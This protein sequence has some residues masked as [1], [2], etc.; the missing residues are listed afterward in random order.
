MTLSISRI[1]VEQ[2]V[3]AVL[4]GSAVGSFALSHGAT[5]AWLLLLP[6]AAALFLRVDG[7]G[8]RGA[9]AA[10]H[11][12]WGLSGVT[13]LL[14]LIL[15]AYPSVLGQSPKALEWVAGIE[16][17]AG[18]T[19][20]V[21]SVLFLL[22]S[23]VWP[24]PSTLL[25]AVL[26]TWVVAAFNAKAQLRWPL[27]IA[28]LAVV[29]DLALSARS[30]GPKET[31]VGPG[32]RR[33]FG[34][35]L[36]IL[37]TAV[38]A[39]G[40]MGFLPW[41]QA[42]L[43]L[44]TFRFVSGQLATQSTVSWR[45]GV[46]SQLGQLQRLKLSRQVVLRV[47][48]SRPQKLRGTVFARFDGR[49]WQAWLVRNQDLSAVPREAILEKGLAE[50]L[51][52]ISGQTYMLAGKSVDHASNAP[53]VRTEIM[54]VA[55]GLVPVLVAPGDAWLVRSSARQL[56]VDDYEALIA[57]TPPS[58][59]QAYGVVNRTDGGVVQAGVP[60]SS[61]VAEC[62]AVPADTDPRLNELA[63][64]LGKG[65]RSE[66][67][68]IE[69][70]V[71]FLQ[72]KCRYSLDVGAFHSRQ[73]VAE[74]VFEKK[75]GYCEYF[76]SAA[77]LLLRLQGVPARYVTGYNVGAGNRQG[78]HYVVRQLD[79]HAWVEAYVAGR[80]WL[81][82]DPTPEAEYLSLHA[83]PQESWWD[84]FT[85]WVSAKW[86][87][88]RMRWRPREWLSA[89]GK[90]RRAGRSVLLLPLALLAVLLGFRRRKKKLG[91]RGRIPLSPRAGARPIAAEHVGIIEGLDR[92]WEHSGYARPA[93]RGP[94]E[95]LASIPAQA[96]SAGQR[97]TSSR[98]V[99]IFYRCAFGGA[100]LS[101]EELRELQ[102]SLEQYVR[103]TP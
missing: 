44:A 7:V 28:A 9:Q 103:P 13:V 72:S 95:H 32:L 56:R 65:A 81:E 58:P 11:L 45:T 43:E 91:V 62:L 39:W 88:A 54:R 21:T 101:E 73:P 83:N 85:E 52:S 5:P 79:A 69:R 55:E 98:A 37:G 66:E 75:K 77:A 86:G 38:L 8:P 25:P 23:S 26:G 96:L 102:R 53:T 71:R 84:N 76:A 42:Q 36:S 40:I 1:T 82:V 64:Q 99:E 49:N 15:M 61:M 97:E 19:L 74:F 70:T 51:S 29:A 59:G 46:Q 17:A 18:Y 22:G 41:A 10:L 60:P 2:T 57:A 94:L 12:V 63:A 27:V 48:T 34:K 30:Y 68:R 33:L 92:L 20:A 90:V 4:V 16:R 14:G 78:D 87:E 93:W 47:W 100:R 6:C 24:A 89:M 3:F 35:G 67:E 31:S 80:G 50:W